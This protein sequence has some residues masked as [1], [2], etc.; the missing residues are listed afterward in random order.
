M[1]KQIYYNAGKANYKL[2]ALAVLLAGIGLFFIYDFSIFEG[3]NLSFDNFAFKQLAA[4]IIG[5]TC[6]VIV[7]GIDYHFILTIAIWLGRIFPFLYVLIQIPFISR[8]IA[9]YDKRYLHIG[10]FSFDLYPVCL[11]VCCLML[12]YLYLQDSFPWIFIDAILSIIPCL[13]FGSVPC[14]LTFFLIVIGYYFLLPRLQTPVL[15]ALIPFFIAFSA[16][17]AFSFLT[18]NF[19]Y[20]SPWYTTDILAAGGAFGLGIGHGFPILFH[21][22]TTLILPG[23]VCEIGWFGAAFI[24]ATYFAFLAEAVKTACRA[25]DAFGFSLGAILTLKFMVSLLLNLFV[26]IGFLPYWEIDLPLL[27]Y[28]GTGLVI[29]FFSIGIL[30]NI[31]RQPRQPIWRKGTL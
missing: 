31:S 9:F 24:L 30:L 20:S 12:S 27:G 10:T 19:N 22:R 17:I 1:K 6:A 4:L 26:T 8:F 14:M 23:I 7:S 16:F 29:D 15:I 25:R 18:D 2:L 5:V 28:G 3:K 21:C 11:F 13:L